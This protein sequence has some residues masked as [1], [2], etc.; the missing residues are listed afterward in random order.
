MREFIGK[1]TREGPEPADDGV[2]LFRALENEPQRCLG[3]GELLGRV[4]HREA[5]LCQGADGINRLSCRRE[6]LDGDAIAL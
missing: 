6:K 1:R 5:L 4:F 3:A 2:V